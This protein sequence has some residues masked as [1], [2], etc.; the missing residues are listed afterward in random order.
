MSD[1]SSS[2]IEYFTVREASSVSSLSVAML[3]YL[4]RH[5]IVIATGS[6]LQGRGRARRYTFA[7]L[8]LLRAVAQ[9]LQRG[10][11]VLRLK[12]GLIAARKRGKTVADLLGKRYLLTDGYNLYFQD[13]GTLE[14][15]ETGQMAFA[16]VL[17]LDGIRSAVRRE[18]DMGRTTALQA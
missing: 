11:S 15:L 17:Q 16:F 7:D 13:S 9:L 14:L 1:T 4:M 2:F 10:V 6:T 18:L 12:Q 5:Q 8:V 3:N